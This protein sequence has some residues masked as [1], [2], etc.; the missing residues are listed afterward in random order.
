MAVRHAVVTLQ[1]VVRRDDASAGTLQW[2]T[3][4]GTH[5]STRIRISVDDENGYLAP[6]AK[7][8][9]AATRLLL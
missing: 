6:P 8:E 3:V 4:V 9:V 5:S 1:R 2:Q 7:A